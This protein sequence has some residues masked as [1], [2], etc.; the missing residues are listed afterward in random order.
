MAGQDRIYDMQLREL[1][2]QNKV[3]WYALQ[4]AERKT[5]EAEAFA[6]RH[7]WR[8]ALPL[9]TVAGALVT[10]LMCVSFQYLTMRES[11][12]HWQ[13]SD[14][15]EPAAC[16]P[17]M[18][19]AL[20]Y[21]SDGLVYCMKTA[22]GDYAWRYVSGSDPVEAQT[23]HHLDFLPLPAWGGDLPTLPK[24]LQDND[25]VLHLEP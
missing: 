10:F 7:K 5:R 18:S 15:A 24:V 16:D 21:R 20:V 9:W 12:V 4:S 8:L 13:K 3:L 23:E 14:E 19:G 1:H 11:G 6:E 2:D 22:A 17:W 25:F